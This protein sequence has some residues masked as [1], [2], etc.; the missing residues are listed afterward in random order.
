MKISVKIGSEHK[1]VYASI[2]LSLK[3][4]YH[5]DVTFIVNDNI[6]KKLLNRMCNNSIKVIVLNNETLVTD[7]STIEEALLAE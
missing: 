2:G 1:G 6:S 4:E 7:E 5:H 3:N